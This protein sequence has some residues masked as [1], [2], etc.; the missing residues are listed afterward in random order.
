M[1]DLVYEFVQR[2]KHSLHNLYTRCIARLS[3]P[4]RIWCELRKCVAPQIDPLPH[5]H[6][7]THAQQTAHT[8]DRHTVYF[9]TERAKVPYMNV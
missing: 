4:Q 2:E 7:H 8:R 3:E 9:C 6:S 5:P 1:Y